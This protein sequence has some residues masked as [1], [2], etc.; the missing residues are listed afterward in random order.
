M[1]IIRSIE[2]EQAFM[3]FLLMCGWEYRDAEYAYNCL[4][5]NKIMAKD[6]Y[7]R[8]LYGDVE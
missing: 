8:G 3:Q 4:F 2:F 5:R 7:L 6:W 1:T